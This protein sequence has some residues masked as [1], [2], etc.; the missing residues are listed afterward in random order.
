[1]GGH[2]PFPR[3]GSAPPLARKQYVNPRL[4]VKPVTARP[5]LMLRQS[6]TTFDAPRGGLDP[7]A[8]TGS[9]I[10]FPLLRLRRLADRVVT[11]RRFATSVTLFC[12]FSRGFVLAAS[13]FW[14]AFTFGG[15]FAAALNA[16][17]TQ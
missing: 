17:A 11:V 12:F 8:S 5:S 10:H 15:S 4:S 2:R 3:T 9:T 14:G 13:L 7:C 16:R 6:T 1:V